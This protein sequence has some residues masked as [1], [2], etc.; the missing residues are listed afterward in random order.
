MKR[1][2][3]TARA[4]GASGAT[5]GAGTTTW[6]AFLD[7]AT[8]SI[9]K[10]CKRL[11]R[12]SPKFK[13]LASSAAVGARAVRSAP[14]TWSCSESLRLPAERAMPDR[15]KTELQLPSTKTWRMASPCNLTRRHGAMADETPSA[16]ASKYR[17]RMAA[18]NTTNTRFQ[19]VR[20]FLRRI[21]ADDFI[22]KCWTF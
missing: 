12:T 8:V 13:M 7:S 4:A 10:L 5:G 11:A 14:L 1:E 19:S 3:A 22:G 2:G 20:R 6:V 9:S 16:A 15:E 21:Q 18:F 17:L